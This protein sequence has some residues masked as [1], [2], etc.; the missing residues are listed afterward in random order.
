MVRV[1]AGIGQI[2]KSV[3]KRERYDVAFRSG[4]GAKTTKCGQGVM[5]A[6][7]E[8]FHLDRRQNRFVGRKDCTMTN[9]DDDK[10]MVGTDDGATSAKRNCSEFMV[11]NTGNIHSSMRIGFDKT[12]LSTK[13]GAVS[14]AV[15]KAASGQSGLG[16]DIVPNG[17][18]MNV[19]GFARRVF[20]WFTKKA[21]D[22]TGWMVRRVV[23]GVVR[24]CVDNEVVIGKL[25]R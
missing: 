18:N 22:R 9:N 17:I 6:N 21:V 8:R 12:H 23:I 25:S 19:V 3:M 1:R 7:L 11:I 5:Y 14:T 10:T 2:G 15:N 16:V 24:E 13:D 20:A 4:N